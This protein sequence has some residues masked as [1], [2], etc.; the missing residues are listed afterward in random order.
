MEIEAFAKASVA[1]VPL[2]FVVM[3]LV[4]LL[5]DNGL[6]RPYWFAAALVLG[7]VLGVGYQYSQAPLATFAGWFA[8]VVYGLGLGLVAA[9][10]Y[11]ARKPG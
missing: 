5:K 7:L 6:A 4:Q 9:K 11:D 8:A 1:G 3:G 10:V 2:L